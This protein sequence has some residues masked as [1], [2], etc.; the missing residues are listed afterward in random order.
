MW[1]SV[2]SL[3]NMDLKSKHS[4]NACLKQYFGVKSLKIIN[5]KYVSFR[6]NK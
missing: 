1:S 6:Y 4:A 2:K 5:N 3:K